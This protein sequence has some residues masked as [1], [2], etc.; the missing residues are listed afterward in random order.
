ML[1]LDRPL[2]FS[3]GLQ[4][5]LSNNHQETEKTRFITDRSGGYTACL[6]SWDWLGG[7][8]D[9][10]KGERR[11]ERGGEGEHSGAWGSAFI[12]VEGGA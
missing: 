5:A 12:G 4:D 9:G 10:R 8:R 7:G 3:L 1:W 11:R 6:R 2:W